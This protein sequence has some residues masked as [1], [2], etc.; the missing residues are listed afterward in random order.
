M[1]IAGPPRQVFR[2]VRLLLRHRVGEA[3]S[4]ARA[5]AWGAD[6]LSVDSR[7]MHVSPRSVA[8]G[9][10]GGMTL[11]QTL[12]A[13]M[14]L[15]SSPRITPHLPTL[16]GVATRICTLES[17][18]DQLQRVSIEVDRRVVGLASGAGA[19]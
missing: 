11:V 8:E 14:A 3:G 4:G 12:G 9:C 6:M 1:L 2:L 5:G 17:L 16:S 10:E 13:T 15:E 18:A 19:S 7:C